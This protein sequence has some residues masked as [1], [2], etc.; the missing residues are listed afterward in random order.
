MAGAA[1]NA[2]AQEAAAT[3]TCAGATAATATTGTA[4]LLSGITR[5]WCVIM[6][7]GVMTQLVISGSCT[8]VIGTFL[9]CRYRAARYHRCT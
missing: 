6:C 2:A 5:C 3:A 7:H 4:W 8:V 1:G 9:V